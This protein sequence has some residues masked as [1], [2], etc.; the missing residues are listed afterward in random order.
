MRLKWLPVK[1]RSPGCGLLILRALGPVVF[2]SVTRQVPVNGVGVIWALA[3]A[4]SKA[5]AKRQTGSFV[6]E[7]IAL[8]LVRDLQFGSR[9]YTGF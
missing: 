9:E 5:I 3:V 8:L 6:S 2:I 7:C 1:I 4:A